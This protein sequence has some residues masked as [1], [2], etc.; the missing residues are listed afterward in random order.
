VADLVEVMGS[1]AIGAKLIDYS[2]SVDMEWEIVK[3]DISGQPE[4]F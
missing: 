4:L 1:K 3:E 2:K